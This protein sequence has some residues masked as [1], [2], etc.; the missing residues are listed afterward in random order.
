LSGAKKSAKYL[1][2]RDGAMSDRHIIAIAECNMWHL[3]ILH[4]YECEMM[5]YGFSVV[6][7]SAKMGQRLIGQDT[8][9]DWHCASNSVAHSIDAL[10][11]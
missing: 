11:K 8:L 3:E 9:P 2:T 7:E 6:R 4:D 10:R 5:E 1:T